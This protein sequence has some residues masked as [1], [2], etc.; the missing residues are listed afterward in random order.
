MLAVAMSSLVLLFSSQAWS[1]HVEKYSVMFAACA[2]PGDSSPSMVL[3]SFTGGGTRF[4]LIVNLQ[5]LATRIVGAD[6]LRCDTLRLKAI[7]H[8]FANLPYVLALGSAEQRSTLVQDAGIVH[9]RPGQ[10]GIILT[11]DLCPSSLPLDRN[12]FNE[13][14]EKFLPEEN[15]IPIA[16]AVS[17]NWMYDHPEDLR[18]LI[19]CADSGKLNITWINHSYNHRWYDSLPLDKN[20]LES[21]GTNLDLEVLKTER[22]MIE[23]RMTPSVFFRFPG[24]VS[25]SLLFRKITAY[26]LIPVGTDA[27]LAKNQSPKSGSIVLVHANGNE[28]YGIRRFFGLLRNHRA[29]IIAG[30]WLLHDLRKSIAAQLDSEAGSH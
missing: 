20:F 28:P 22:K 23:N 17:G 14:I 6:S 4:F 12:F 2:I 3:R 7:R 25:D 16:L 21:K 1:Y 13:L 15:P 29:G 27:W 26:G 9:G 30:S 18:W 5:T 10:K 24:L 8:S 11:A 19:G